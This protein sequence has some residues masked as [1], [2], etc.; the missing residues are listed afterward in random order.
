VA[1]NP[2]DF[3][4]IVTASFRRFAGRRP[5]AREREILR[6]LYDEQ[7]TAFRREPEAAEQYLGIGER[8][9]NVALPAVDVA[10][11]AVLVSTLMN[12]DEFVMKR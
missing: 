7:L 11:T 8:P 12:H 9:R 6:R 10:A 3:D 4:S 5:D 2:A 1:T